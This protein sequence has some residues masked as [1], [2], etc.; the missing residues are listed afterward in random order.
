MGFWRCL[1]HW[2]PTMEWAQGSAECSPSATA[3]HCGRQDGSILRTKHRPS[4]VLGFRGI[5]DL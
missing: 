5:P 2:V 1:G 3:V 4:S